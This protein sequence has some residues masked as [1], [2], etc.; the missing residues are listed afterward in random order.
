MVLVDGNGEGLLKVTVEGLAWET[1]GDEITKFL[2][3]RQEE[4]TV[5]NKNMMED[6]AITR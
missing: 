5:G 1:I 2:Q 4:P 3:S 6:N